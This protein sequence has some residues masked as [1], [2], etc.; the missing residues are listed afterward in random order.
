MLTDKELEEQ[1]VGAL[2]RELLGKVR[3]G[4]PVRAVRGSG[5]TS[6]GRHPL[7]KMGTVLQY[8]NRTVERPY[9]MLYENDPAVVEYYDPAQLSLTYDVVIH[10]GA[11][12]G[13]RRSVTV[14][15]TRDF[16]VLEPGRRPR[17][18]ECKSEDRRRTPQC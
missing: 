15:H 7:S 5:G 1:G 8:E 10:K 16:L 2:G 9:L 13:Q 4:D 17:F 18:V 6:T 12:A 11:R 14:S 3:S